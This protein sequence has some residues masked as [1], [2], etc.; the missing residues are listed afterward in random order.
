VSSSQRFS[1][2]IPMGAWYCHHLPL[3]SRTTITNIIQS[4]FRKLD[5]TQM[6]CEQNGDEK[7]SGRC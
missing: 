6:Q 1:D 2:R 3:Y 7:H 5:L 4:Q